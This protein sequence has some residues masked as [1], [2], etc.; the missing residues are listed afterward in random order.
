MVSERGIIA[1]LASRIA[2]QDATI[3]RIN[4]GDRDA[5]STVNIVLAAPRSPR[6][7]H[8]PHPDPENPCARCSASK[9]K[10]EVLLG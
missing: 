7:H 3:K 1:T 9:L 8:A 4:V 5:A 6:Q 2:E 10:P